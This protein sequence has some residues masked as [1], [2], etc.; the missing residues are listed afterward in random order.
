LSY[1]GDDE[2][3]FWA[4]G[5]GKF[6]E[7]GFDEGASGF[8]GAVGAEV[9]EDHGVVVADYAARECGFSGRGF[10]GD[11]GGDHEFVRDAF[12]VACADG[13]DGIGEF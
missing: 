12:F 10:G 6:F 1:G 9:E 11:D 2:K 8:A 5:V 4:R 3:I 13:G 7:A